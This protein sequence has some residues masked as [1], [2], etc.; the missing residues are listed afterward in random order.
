MWI[1]SDA[2]FSVVVAYRCFCWCLS[3][4]CSWTL[5]VIF[6]TFPLKWFLLF[7]CHA[8]SCSQTRKM[9]DDAQYGRRGVSFDSLP[10]VCLV[11]VSV[12]IKSRTFKKEENVSHSVHSSLK[13]PISSASSWHHHTSWWKVTQFGKSSRQT[14]NSR[15]ARWG[16]VKSDFQLTHI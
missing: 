1:A 5:H 13:F 3:C 2:I 16:T 12:M 11:F 8:C 7:R 10:S 6:I 15:I 4:C 9:D 14:C